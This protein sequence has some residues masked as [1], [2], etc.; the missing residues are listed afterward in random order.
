MF[1]RQR[2]PPDGRTH[3]AVIV[4]QLWEK[5]NLCNAFCADI[6]AVVVI[7][8]E[9]ADFHRVGGTRGGV[10]E[11]SIADVNPHMRAGFAVAAG[12]ITEKN[13]ITG[14]QVL[15]GHICTGVVPL[16]RGGVGEA[17]EIGRVSCRERVLRLV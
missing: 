11:I 9:T 1:I 2:K 12:G 6:V 14:L 5:C 17:V 13:Q 7:F 15:T 3:P 8:A 4:T 16:G 10:D